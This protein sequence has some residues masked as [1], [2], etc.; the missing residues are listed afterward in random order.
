MSHWARWIWQWEGRSSCHRSMASNER[1]QYF[2][3]PMLL[4]SRMRRLSTCCGNWND[5]LR[6]MIKLFV[7]P[8]GHIIRVSSWIDIHKSVDLIPAHWHLDKPVMIILWNCCYILIDWHNWNTVIYS[9]QYLSFGV[10]QSGKVYSTA[11]LF[12]F[13]ISDSVR[14]SR[15][16]TG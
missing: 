16:L 2:W 11:K 5:F 1:A 6:R 8:Q 10:D 7:L 3:F 14:F 4:A 9:D 15:K 13:I 12:K